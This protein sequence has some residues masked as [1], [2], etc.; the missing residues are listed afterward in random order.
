MHTSLEPDMGAPVS[1]PSSREWDPMSFEAELMY[2]G[3][4]QSYRPMD[5]PSLDGPG[6][7][8]SM[9]EPALFNDA[10]ARLEVPT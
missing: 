9:L 5:S 3:A 6:V 4:G 2:S 8:S 7:D 10:L 1:L